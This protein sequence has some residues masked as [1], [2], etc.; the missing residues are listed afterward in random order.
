MGGY[1]EHLVYVRFLY[2]GYQV[3]PGE[4]GHDTNPSP[5]SSAAD[6]KR[7]ELCLYSPCGPHGLYGASVP[8]QGYTLPSLCSVL[9][10]IRGLGWCS[11]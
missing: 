7:V 11:G 4:S 5:P 9:L 8:V 3:F 10:L 6:H 1:F 2:D